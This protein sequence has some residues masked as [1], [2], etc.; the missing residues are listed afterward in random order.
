[1]GKFTSVCCFEVLSEWLDVAKYLSF[2]PI[3]DKKSSFLCTEVVNAHYISSGSYHAGLQTKKL[4][5]FM[6]VCNFG[7][8]C[9]SPW[10]SAMPVR[11]WFAKGACLFGEVTVII[12]SVDGI[13]FVLVMLHLLIVI[14]SSVQLSA[15][16]AGS[17]WCDINDRN[18][19]LTSQG[20]E[21]LT[22][23]CDHACIYTVSIANQPLIMTALLRLWLGLRLYNLLMKVSSCWNKFVAGFAPTGMLCGYAVTCTVI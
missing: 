20:W 3:L 13:S 7:L 17:S 6:L 1:M 14:Y 11:A 16:E 8:V 19:V 15:N 4:I 5:H 12:C 21:H 22:R 2:C 23:T 9:F 10:A 18:M